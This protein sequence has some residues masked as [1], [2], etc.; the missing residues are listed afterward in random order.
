MGIEVQFYDFRNLIV[1]TTIKNQ[2]I[3]R[4][5]AVEQDVDT[6]DKAY[7]LTCGERNQVLKQLGIG[8]LRS[9]LP[10]SDFAVANGTK[11]QTGVSPF[12]HNKTKMMNYWLRPGKFTFEDF[13]KNKNNSGIAPDVNRA[14]IDAGLAPVM[15]L[16]IQKIIKLQKRI[17]GFG[18]INTVKDNHGN[19]RYHTITIGL[20]PEKIAKE[21]KEL[22]WLYQNE[23][24][25]FIAT[26]KTFTDIEHKFI[27]PEGDWN[28][29]CYE[30]VVSDD[31]NR[32]YCFQ[33]KYY[34]RAKNHPEFNH[35]EGGFKS[36]ARAGYV[37]LEE[38]PKEWI[39][40]NDKE[41]LKALDPKKHGKAKTMTVWAG[42]VMRSGIPFYSQQALCRMPHFEQEIAYQDSMVRNYL[43]GEGEFRECNFL[44][45]S[46]VTPGGIYINKEREIVRSSTK[47]G[48]SLLIPENL[49]KLHEL[50]REMIRGEIQLKHPEIDMNKFYEDLGKVIDYVDEA[51]KR[52]S[53]E[54]R[55]L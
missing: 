41:A 24:N 37:W 15:N 3:G 17:P 50:N 4:G 47:S 9:G 13:F 31:I 16:D 2:H 5:L 28:K 1:P 52:Q 6:V 22:E 32:E 33:G 29:S 14:D 43:N 23:P 8:P 21:T 7:I 44:T 42:E 39:I 20:W 45:E 35:G 48:Q 51:E 11:F 25:R 49:T 40:L 18:K 26:G 38:K 27:V 53:G 30:H 34:V 36:E 55:S 46:L 19:E 54:E 12:T 10:A